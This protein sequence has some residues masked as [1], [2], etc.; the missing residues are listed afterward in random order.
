MDKLPYRILRFL[1]PFLALYAATVN[2]GH[3]SGPNNLK[4]LPIP[5][6]PGFNDL[7]ERRSDEMI[8]FFNF[9]FWVLLLNIG[10][11]YIQVQ[12]EKGDFKLGKI[13]DKDFFASLIFAVFILYL[14]YLIGFFFGLRFGGSL[15]TFPMF[16]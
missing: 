8:T 16:N 1:S 11:G 13:F 14:N 7:I 10:I 15:E 2:L 3:P 5:Y 4:G 9:F 6:S 12:R